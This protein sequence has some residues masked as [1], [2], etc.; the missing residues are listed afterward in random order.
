MVSTL[1]HDFIHR[2]FLC[3]HNKIWRDSGIG[4]YTH[5]TN[6]VNLWDLILRKLFDKLQMKAPQTLQYFFH[7]VPRNYNTNSEERK[8]V[9][10][11]F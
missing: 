8:M 2:K 10:R 3:Y 6:E 1:D 7:D 4:D 5:L 11:G 9:V